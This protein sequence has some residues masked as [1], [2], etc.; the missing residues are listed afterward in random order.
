MEIFQELNSEGTTIV[1]VTHEREL[2]RM[3]HRVVE[4]KDGEIVEETT[5]V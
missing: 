2:T 3:T 1:M 4:I 5:L